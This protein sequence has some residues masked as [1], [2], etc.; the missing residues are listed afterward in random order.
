MAVENGHTLVKAHPITGR[1]HQLRVHFA[2][3][4]H[5][6]TG[7]DLYGNPSPH[8]A[9]HALHAYTLTLP[10]PSRDEQLTVRAPLSDDLYT[11]LHTLFPKYSSQPEERLFL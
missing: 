3:I 10:H 2:S 7:D 9:R 11:L 6:I 5:P 8:I 4:G 1:T